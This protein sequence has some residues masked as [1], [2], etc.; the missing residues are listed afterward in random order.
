MDKHYKNIKQLIEN[1]LVEIKKLEIST[2][3]HTL[4]TYHNVGKELIEAQGGKERAKYGNN[5]IKQ[6][7]FKLTREFGKGY[8][9]SNLKK[10]RQFYLCFQKGATVCNTNNLRINNYVLY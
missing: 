9:V 6:Y 2:N 7:S 10:M 5:L 4:L 3:Y 8:D 1:N